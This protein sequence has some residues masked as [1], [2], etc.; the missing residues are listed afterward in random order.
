MDCTFPTIGTLTRLRYP[1]SI[2]LI[3]ITLVTNSTAQTAN[4]ASKSQAPWQEWI[5]RVQLNTLDNVSE[6]TRA[7][8]YAIGYSDWTDKTTTLTRGQSYPLSITPGLSWSGYQTSLFFRVWIDFNGNNIFEDTEKVLEQNNG[9]QSVTSSIMIPTT[10]VLGSKKMRVSMKKDAYATACETFAAGEVE[11]Y[12][13]VI[14]GTTTSSCANNVLNFDGIDDYIQ[15]IQ[16]VI[17]ANT[18]FTMEASFTSTATGTGCS[19]NFKR[20]LTLNIANSSNRLEIGECGGQLTL[21]YFISGGGSRLINMP[22]ATNL[23]DGN[24]HHVAAAKQGDALKI[25]YDGTLVLTELGMTNINNLPRVLYVGRW[26]LQGENWQG[27]VD[28][29]R[30]WNYAVSAADVNTRRL[31]QLTGNE[32]GLTLYYPFNQGVSGGNNATV[33]NALDRSPAGVT[34][35]MVNFGLSGATSNWI[36][37]TQTLTQGCTTTDPVCGQTTK[38]LPINIT[39]NSAT[40][41]WQRVAT[42]INYSYEL[43]NDFPAGSGPTGLIASGTATDTFIN[44]NGI[45]GGR[46]QVFVRVNCS[47]GGASAWSLPI[48]FTTLEV[49]CTQGALTTLNEQFEGTTQGFLPLCWRNNIYRERWDVEANVDV[50]PT[51]RGTINNNTK[52]AIMYRSASTDSV[53]IMAVTPE[54]SNVGAGTHRLRFKAANTWTTFSAGSG[55]IQIGTSSNA[56]DPSTFTPFGAPT[57]ITDNAFREYTVDFANYR[58]SDRRIAFKYVDSGGDG[59]FSSIEFDDVIWEQTPVTS[60]DVCVNPTANIIGGANSITISGITTS[61]A[62][63]QVFNSNWSLVDARQVSSSTATIPNLPA[64]T[65]NVKVSVLGAGGT[66]PSICVAQTSVVVTTGSN[67]CANDVTPPVFTNCPSNISLT[68]TGTTAIGTWATVQATDNCTAQP[69]VSSVYA[70][71]YAFPIGTTTVTYTAKDAA[72]N[73]STCSFTVTV[74]AIASCGQPTKGLATAITDTSVVVKWQRVPSAT[75]YA[76]ELRTNYAPGSG[77]SS[78]I[79]SGTTTDTFVRIGF[80][81][82]GRYQAFVKA[83]CSVGTSEWS[84]P[85]SF[86]TLEVP[87]NQGALTELNENF[88]NVNGNVGFL[89]TCWR[90]NTTRERW[91][92]ETNVDVRPLGRGTINN[93]TKRAVMYR[94][95]STDSV[96]IM[97][98]TPELSNVGAGT[99]RLRFKAANTWGTPY[100]G[101]GK[102]QIGTSSNAFDPTT[103]TP[104]GAP[105]T[106]LDNTFQ[107]YTVNFANY[108]GTDRYIAFKYVDGGGDASFR[109]LEFDDVVWERTPVGTAI[110]DIS[111]AMGSPQSNYRQWTPITILV[112]ATNSGTT[113]MT[114]VKVEL[115]RPDKTASGGAKVPS[116]GTFNDYCAGGIECSEWVIPSLAVGA[117]VTLDAPFFVL[118]ATLP[119]VVTA[120]LLS[121]TPTDT[122]LTNNLVTISIPPQTGLVAPNPAQLVYQKPTQL[123]PIVIQR[124]APNPTEGELIVKLESLD[125]REVT[126]NFYNTLGKLVKSEKKTVGKGMNRVE[127]TVY[128]LEQGVHFIVPTTTQGHKVPTKFVKM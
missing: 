22:N 17:A 75:S 117:T 123:I 120:K 47:G 4:C 97:A 127:F 50:R 119:I 106:I 9:N 126:F 12:T 110:N 112:S 57:V 114:N 88:D 6:K 34:S 48:S 93:N 86:T 3:L 32:T 72:N 89:P 49:P 15:T 68:T 16:P 102:I 67:P 101:V 19:G 26:G 36:C 71:R 108:R 24:W 55:R 35:Y 21:F 8:R 91:D 107:E 82:T 20:L 76:Y 111:I 60:G 64:G 99:H 121:S 84:K 25:Y 65:Y 28:E 62:V 43:R 5:G 77:A 46:Y 103:F 95:T 85:I 115:K 104:F 45:G 18:D 125:E 83:N 100:A 122:G 74:T 118:D 31:C 10:A 98:V 13:V 124:I 40:I 41:K 30:V 90:N 80:G 113:A 7:D 52:R 87:C 39:N 51:G 56:F 78:L 105:T 61:A 128:E 70:P 79:K 11:D 58:G 116:V 66:W 63:I 53:I 92:V 81:L 96:I 59:S 109:S 44:L 2:F 27:S 54:L 1:L 14:D 42:A 38:G 29:V 69:T 73:T 23:R 94:S 33:N 37:S